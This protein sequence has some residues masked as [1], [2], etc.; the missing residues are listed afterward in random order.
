LTELL[1]LE[2][3]EAEVLRFPIKFALMGTMLM[4]SITPPVITHAFAQGG[5]GPDV[6]GALLGLKPRPGSD[7][8]AFLGLA[9]QRHVRRQASHDRHFY[10][11]NKAQRINAALKPHEAQQK[12]SLDQVPDHITR[13]NDVP[14][15]GAPPADRGPAAPASI[16]EPEA[17]QTVGM[18][19]VIRLPEAPQSTPSPIVESKDTLIRRSFEALSLL[20]VMAGAALGLTKLLASGSRIIRSWTRAWSTLT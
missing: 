17:R 5:Y 10:E 4:A 7:I 13:S 6:V 3:Q 16:I 8:D 20:I 19:P 18:A 15:A 1:T 9:P 11:S 14:T 12:T 2:N